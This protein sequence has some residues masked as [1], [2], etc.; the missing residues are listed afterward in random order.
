[1]AD[2][3]LKSHYR[4]MEADEAEMARYRARLAERLT[5]PR[6]WPGWLPAASIAA[7]AAVL[8]LLWVALPGQG[9]PQQDL[10]E[11]QALAESRPEKARERARML[12]LR[13]ESQDRWN[14]L[15]LLSLT[16]PE[17]VAV[18]YAAQGLQEDPRAEFRCF[19]LEYLLDH[20]DEYQ[21]NVTLLENLMDRE[22]DRLCFKL[23]G[24]L[25]RLVS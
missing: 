7:A 17:Q 2:E 18:H 6:R 1:M 10:E 23:Y 15:A 21:Y 22:P 16:E 9:L 19:Y 3:P 12:V 5:T 20:A 8:V 14:A 24:Q 25:L 11:I 13:G 4:G